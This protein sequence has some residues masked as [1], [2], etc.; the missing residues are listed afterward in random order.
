MLIHRGDAEIRRVTSC[1]ESTSAAAIKMLSY[2]DLLMPSDY[3][4]HLHLMSA[5]IIW[6]LS[7]VK[8]PNTNQACRTDVALLCHSNIKVIT[9]LLYMESS[10][11]Q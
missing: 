4:I 10:G 1:M 9:L 8:S 5:V 7:A 11:Q 3:Y 6:I 2:Q